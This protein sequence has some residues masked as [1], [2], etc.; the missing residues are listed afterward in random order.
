MTHAPHDIGDVSDIVLHWHHKSTF[1]NPFQWNPFGL[2]H[3][4]LYI[5]KVQVEHGL[6]Q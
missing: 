6:K 3:P 5:S 1:V 4:T 2:R